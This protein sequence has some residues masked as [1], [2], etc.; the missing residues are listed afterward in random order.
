M[1]MAVA[2]DVARVAGADGAQR[3]LHRRKHLASGRVEALS[4]RGPM[5]EAFGVGRNGLG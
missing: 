4:S 5:R 1:H 3:L 2:G